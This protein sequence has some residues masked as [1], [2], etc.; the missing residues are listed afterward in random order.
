MINDV[1]WWLVGDGSLKGKRKINRNV[2][3]ICIDVDVSRCVVQCAWSFIG[4][5]IF[6]ALFLRVERSV[7]W[8][9]RSRRRGEEFLGEVAAGMVL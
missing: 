1:G 3:S 5:Q 8:G 2:V 6:V 4:K 9:W 7:Q